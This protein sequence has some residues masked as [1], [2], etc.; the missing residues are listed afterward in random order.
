VDELSKLPYVIEVNKVD[1][2][3][4]I[5]VKLHGDNMN[6]IEGSIEKVMT[7]INGVESIVTLTAQD[8]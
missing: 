6:A 4:D 2:P 7:R 3:Y 1:G 5:I 8:D